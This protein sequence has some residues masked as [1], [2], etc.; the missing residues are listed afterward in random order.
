[1]KRVAIA[2]S[3][4]FA[5]GCSADADVQ[6]E[7]LPPSFCPSPQWTVAFAVTPDPAE[8]GDTLRFEWELRSEALPP[9]DVTVSGELAGAEVVWTLDLT[10]TASQGGFDTYSAEV[11]HPFGSTLVGATLAVDGTSLRPSGCAEPA[12]A[13][14]TFSVD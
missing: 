5:A 1:M 11:A 13:A 10:R 9:I 7:P 8:V 4:L 6:G 2:C 3:M 12:R 14:T